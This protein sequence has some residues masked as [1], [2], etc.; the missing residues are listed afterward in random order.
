MELLKSKFNFSIMD[1]D[2]FDRAELNFEKYTNPIKYTDNKG[3]E[4][5]F[6]LLLKNIHNLYVKEYEI[7][8]LE[9]CKENIKDEDSFYLNF[10]L[11]GLL[12]MK[13]TT[14]TFNKNPLE[15]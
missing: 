3:E 4:V 11:S 12:P 2:F 8:T 14:Y 15:R 9:V 10:D 13:K 6:N 1:E 5:K 7:N